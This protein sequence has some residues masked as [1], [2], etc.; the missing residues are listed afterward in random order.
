[1]VACGVGQGRQ[2]PEHGASYLLS[3]DPDFG[4]GSYI[5][6]AWEKGKAS[7]WKPATDKYLQHFAGD[8]AW[9]V[10]IF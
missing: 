5:R 10:S 4:D 6:P 2:A 8:K 1:M 3:W 7:Q 9:W